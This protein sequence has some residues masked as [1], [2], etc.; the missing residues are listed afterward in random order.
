MSDEI[1]TPIDEDYI[2][3][4]RRRADV[5]SDEEEA[6]SDTFER[7]SRAHQNADMGRTFD[8]SAGAGAASDIDE[9][10]DQNAIVEHDGRAETRTF[11]YP[12][13]APEGRRR[14]MARMLRWQ[15][16][17]RAPERDAQNK[18]A[19][20]FRWVDTFTS[21]LEMT[22]LQQERVQL[23]VDEVNMKHMANYSAEKVIL[24]IITLVANEDDRW[25]REE[26]GFRGLMTDL[27][28]DLDEIKSIR[29]LIRTKSE[30]V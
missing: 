25:I 8:M 26:D 23:V 4:T 13:E 19:D 27:D 10:I 30:H 20:R 11:Y 21:E 6:E 16:G 5:S 3:V 17:E 2:D 22:D 18:E 28:S 24:G 12:S 29:K 15:E 9:L 7:G 14:R 1:D